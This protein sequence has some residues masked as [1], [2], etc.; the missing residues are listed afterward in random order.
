[1]SYLHFGCN[2]ETAPD[3]VKA[4]GFCKEALEILRNSAL[5]RYNIPFLSGKHWGDDNDNDG[6]T[7]SNIYCRSNLSGSIAS[8]HSAALNITY[9]SCVSLALHRMGIC[10]L[11][12]GEYKVA[13]EC[14][15]KAVVLQKKELVNLL[16]QPPTIFLVLF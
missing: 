12:T 9:S 3:L 7:S 8:S 10:Y 5:W 11:N 16:T 14:L 4:I 1:V 15:R 6:S 2:E 13:V